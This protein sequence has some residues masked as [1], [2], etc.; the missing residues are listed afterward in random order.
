MG[1]DHD[2]IFQSL[3]LVDGHDPDGRLIT[4]D[5]LLIFITV[6]DL[7]VDPL[8]QPLQLF[9]CII[10]SPLGYLVNDLRQLQDVRHRPF[11]IGQT[12]IGEQILHP[13]VREE[14]TQHHEYSIRLPGCLVL[15]KALQDSLFIGLAQALEIISSN[16]RKK[17]AIDI[18]TG[19]VIHRL[20]DI[21]Q[22]PRLIGIKKLRIVDRHRRHTLARQHFLDRTTFLV[23]AHENADVLRLHIP[24]FSVLQ[25]LVIWIAQ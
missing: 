23:R 8:L 11:R 4:F 9:T 20:H 5:P 7:P 21:E 10:L 22:L 6:T 19:D 14:T 12:R 18:R 17:R 2:I 16:A 1:G 15:P 24:E 13:M 25:D 3:T